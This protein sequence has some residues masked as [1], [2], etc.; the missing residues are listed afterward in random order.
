MS[1]NSAVLAD[2]ANDAEAFAAKAGDAA[3]ELARQRGG[4][5]HVTETVVLDASVLADA[6]CGSGPVAN[7]ARAH[8]TGDAGP[9]PSTCV[10]RRSV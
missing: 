4:P 1:T 10:S 9:R 3:A 8:S 7:A 6:L 5:R 2:A